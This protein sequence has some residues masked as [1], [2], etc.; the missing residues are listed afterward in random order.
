[1]DQCRTVPP[2]PGRRREALGRRIQRIDRRT[3]R[4]HEA[5]RGRPPGDLRRGL[6]QIASRAS[7]APD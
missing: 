4:G 1:M 2:W 3:D 5:G 7:A 6:F